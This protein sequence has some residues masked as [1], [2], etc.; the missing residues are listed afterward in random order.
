VWTNGTPQSQTLCLNCPIPDDLL[1]IELYIST[2]L[3][4]LPRI[5][6]LAAREREGGHDFL[7][8]LA[9]LSAVGPIK[10]P[11]FCKLGLFF[12]PCPYL[13]R[14]AA[15]AVPLGAIEFHG[16]FMSLW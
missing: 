4:K 1:G 12:F 14:K 15:G 5:L 8:Q 3:S 13:A 7:A 9:H 16:V 2:N 10:H 11:R 6:L